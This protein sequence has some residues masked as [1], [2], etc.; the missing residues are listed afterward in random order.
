MASPL[1]SGDELETP[2]A[3]FFFGS[4]P[5]S[6]SLVGPGFL[7]LE[8]VNE[9]L[10]QRTLSPET[11][12]AENERLNARK[13]FDEIVELG[14]I[15]L[16]PFLEYRFEDLT[17]SQRGDDN[18]EEYMRC[19]YMDEGMYWRAQLRLW[20]RFAQRRRQDSDSSLHSLDPTTTVAAFTTYLRG[21]LQ[22]DMEDRE[23]PGCEVWSGYL[24]ME[25]HRRF[26]ELVVENLPLSE[27]LLRQLRKE[28]GDG[29]VA[30]VEV[31][32]ESLNKEYNI[33]HSN[34]WEELWDHT[35]S[36]LANS[37]AEPLLPAK[38]Q[39]DD[40]DEDADEED[41]RPPKRVA[42]SATSNAETTR[43]SPE[44]DQKEPKPPTSSTSS[45]RD[46]WLQQG[47]ES[48]ARKKPNIS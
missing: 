14:G 9:K 26:I 5:P 42:P 47:R 35:Q 6:P 41:A 21:H 4:R 1:A 48:L 29:S 17:D 18:G 27:A 46:S 24:K 40:A 30:E 3:R 23:Y 34:L 38:R 28:S 45:P 10:R 31:T 25:H 33:P 11:P 13:L 39:R 15:P 36:S 32:R 20:T 7:N 37:E 16:R 2:R 44:G 12:S 19:R 8:V 43:L 22:R